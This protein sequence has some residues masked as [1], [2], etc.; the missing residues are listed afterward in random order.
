[1]GWHKYV[2]TKVHYCNVQINRFRRK[3]YSSAICGTNPFK[4]GTDNKKFITC[5]KCLKILK[6]NGNKEKT[7]ILV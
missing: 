2:P 4:K 6:K 7:K 1:M 5:K 3:I